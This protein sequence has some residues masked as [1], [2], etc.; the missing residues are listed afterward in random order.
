MDRS[1]SVVV[2]L[3]QVG[4][5]DIQLVGGKCANLGELTAKGISVPPGFAVTADA[6]RRFLEETRIGDV[7]HK[8]L[9]SSKGPRDPKQYEEASQEI[10]KIIESAPMPADIAEEVRLA[11]HD[12]EKKTGTTQVKVAVR[13][14]ATAEDLPGASFAGQQDTFLN[15]RG[16]QALLDAVRRC[17]A[18]L[19]T[20]RAV[21]YREDMGF[22]H[23]DVALSVGVQKM[24]RSDLAASGVLFTLDPES[25]HR[26]V[27]LITGSWG[28]GE[29][30]V[31]GQVVPDQFYV[32]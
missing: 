1:H 27:A 11:Y 8:T 19:F 26:G 7:I 12:L 17:F 16:E 14:S 9:N 23:L 30:I 28:L 10:R 21:G 31:Q 13:S 32:H 29:A 24:V 18:S 2:L 22:D 25:G 15:V 20:A 4:K 3:D 6:F 5:N